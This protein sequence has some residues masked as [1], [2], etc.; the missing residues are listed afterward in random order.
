MSSAR[1]ESGDLLEVAEHC[2]HCSGRA[3][4]EQLVAVQRSVTGH[5]AIACR[6]GYAVDSQCVFKGKRHARDS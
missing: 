1:V 4:P 3:S 5:V 2:R 6:H